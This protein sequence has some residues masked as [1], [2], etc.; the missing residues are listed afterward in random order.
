MGSIASVSQEGTAYLIRQ[1][2][3]AGEKW[4][5]A[6]EALVNGIQA[7]ATSI[8]FGVEPQGFK[9]KG[10]LRRYIA[11][12]G[13]GMSPD[14]IKIFLMSFG[15]GGRPIGLT[16]NFGQGFKSSCYEWNPYGIIVVSW[17]KDDP[18]GC[19]I[20]IHRVARAG[21]IYWELKDFEVDEDG[22]VEDVVAP[23]YLDEIGVDV[24]QL[25]TKDIEETGQGTVFLFLGRSPDDD[26]HR[27]DVDRGEDKVKRGI[28][29]YINSRFLEIPEGVT[30]RVAEVEDR[31]RSE[32][33]TWQKDSLESPAGTLLSLDWRRARGALAYIP[34]TAQRGRF[35][36]KHDTWVDWY[37][38]G[39]DIVTRGQTDG[40]ATPHICL[41]YEGE[42]YERKTT[43][44]DYRPF[45]LIEEFRNR[46]WLVLTPPKY[47][48]GR[49][50]WGVFP[51]GSRGQLLSKGGT[52]LPWADWEDSFALNMPKPIQDALAEFRKSR[53]SPAD[54]TERRERLKRIAARLATRFRPVNLIEHALGR[55]AGNDSSA[56]TG[57]PR[58]HVKAK[59][60]NKPRPS[61]SSPGRQDTGGAGGT[62]LLNEDRSGDRFGAVRRSSDGIPATC[63]DTHFPE[64]EGAHAARF[65]RADCV[66]GSYGTVHFNLSFPLF[67]SEFQYWIEQYPKAASEDVVDLVKGVYE[68]EVISKVMHAHKMSGQLLY[69]LEGDD[70][71]RVNN[72]NIDSWT[73]PEAL[74]AAVLGLINVEQ[75]INVLAGS[76][77]GKKKP[78]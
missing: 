6:R 77:F 10:V 41:A 25:K 18:E 38:A 54:S 40:P 30:A 1:A 58:V 50:D 17:T 12:N 46:L 47:E 57:E 63:W 70:A 51:Q 74:T 65:D 39:D 36:L 29:I 69:A 22:A 48:E 45:G 52:P 8:E 20:W 64:D 24:A 19:M 5:W 49:P 9:S 16:Q 71:A 59:R 34:D 35:K 61:G 53:S 75:R 76:R 72:A 60:P 27:G 2:Y 55:T 44:R 14:D 42:S 15:G 7:Q 23:C 4:Q 3:E 62:A 73:S 21:K 31:T 66:D 78:A 56:R 26:T 28:I 13:I 67:Q 32:P 37:L 11:D 43:V 68:D 33:G